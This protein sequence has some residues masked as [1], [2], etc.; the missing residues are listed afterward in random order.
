MRN[1][2]FREGSFDCP[3][4]AITDFEPSEV[5]ALRREIMALATGKTNLVVLDGEVSITLKTGQRDTG[6]F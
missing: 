3:L 2:F 4:V 1:V 5:A 6:T